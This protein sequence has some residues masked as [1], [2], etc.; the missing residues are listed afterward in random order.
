MH[1]SLISALLISTLL[2]ACETTQLRDP[3][4][5]RQAAAVRV[6]DGGLPKEGYVILG[7]VQGLDCSATWY[8]KATPEM[9]MQ[10]LKASAAAKG[11]NAIANI[12]CENTGWSW[13]HNCNNSVTCFGDAVLVISQ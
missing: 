2:I 3:Q 11:A 6:L 7:E 12:A 5:R 9:A 1:K 13:V 10:E 8:S 4:I